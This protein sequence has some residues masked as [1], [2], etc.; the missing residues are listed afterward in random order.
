MACSVACV[1]GAGEGDGLGDGEG[2]GDGVGVKVGVTYWKSKLIGTFAV[3]H[4]PP[5]LDGLQQPT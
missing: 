3:V 1:H 5:L 2:D 4:S